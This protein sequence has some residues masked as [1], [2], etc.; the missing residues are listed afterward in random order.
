MAY[1]SKGSEYEVDFVLTPPD[2][3]PVGVEVK[4]HPTQNDDK[5][6][7]RIAQKN[8]LSQSWV[9]GRFPIPGFEDF[10]WGGSIF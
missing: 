4:Y 1:L 8:G 2:A 9:V 10:L 7:K 6:L 3:Q 5:K